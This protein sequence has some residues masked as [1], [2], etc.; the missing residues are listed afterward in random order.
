MQNNIFKFGDT[1]WEQTSRTAMGTSPGCNYGTIYYSLEDQ[2]YNKDNL[3]D[4]QKVCEVVGEL[5]D[6]G[7]EQ[8]TN[9][10]E[11]SF[12]EDEEL[13]NLVLSIIDDE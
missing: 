1:Y 6:L 11:E 8:T 7:I 4:R 10:T 3:E 2:M 12:D 13:N 9:K 5:E